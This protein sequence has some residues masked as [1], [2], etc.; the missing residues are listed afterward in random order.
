MRTGSVEHKTTRAAFF[1]NIKHRNRCQ[2]V[3]Q[4]PRGINLGLHT[5]ICFDD[6]PEANAACPLLA[7][8]EQRP[9]RDTL[10]AR[11]PAP[12]AYRF[13]IRLQGDA[14]TVFFDV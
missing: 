11:K 3:D 12:G 1:H 8:I 10:L 2:R 13:D 6:E 4:L 9:R 7:R 14:E 5:R